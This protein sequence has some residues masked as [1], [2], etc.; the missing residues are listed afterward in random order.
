MGNRKDKHGNGR[1]G[2]DNPVPN[3]LAS[4]IERLDKLEGKMAKLQLVVDLHRV[5]SMVVEHPPERRPSMGQ[6]S[7]G[8]HEFVFP[9][10]VRHAIPLVAGTAR[11]KEVEIHNDCGGIEG[12]FAV[13]VRLQSGVASRLAVQAWRDEE[14]KRG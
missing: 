9:W 8:C 4:L 6:Y 13:L 1:S 5:D 14:W 3:P 12:K 2:R 11:V 10:P 7:L